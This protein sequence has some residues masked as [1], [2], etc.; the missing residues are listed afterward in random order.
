MN[1][2]RVI[3]KILLALTCSLALVLVPVVA[4][5]QDTG[6]VGTVKH[7][8]QK[9]AQGVEEGGKAVVGKTQEGYDATKKAVTGEDQKTNQKTTE[10]TATE[11]TTTRSTTKGATKGTTSETGKTAGKKLPGTA[12]ELPLTGLLGTLAM[13]GAAASWQIERRKRAKMN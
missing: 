2:D 8:V 4:G 7:G 13:A 12:G 3:Q 6:V 10:G 5:A 11:S 1:I 9:G